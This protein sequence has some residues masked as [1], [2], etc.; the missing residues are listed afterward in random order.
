MERRPGKHA[1][2]DRQL[3]TLPPALSPPTFHFHEPRRRAFLRLSSTVKN[4]FNESLTPEAIAA[5]FVQIRKPQTP[6]ALKHLAG[7][8]RRSA[9]VPAAP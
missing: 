4:T 5:T 3:D 8:P 2:S 1:T 7:V 6:K 9:E